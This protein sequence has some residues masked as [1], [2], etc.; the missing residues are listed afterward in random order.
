MARVLFLRSNP[1]APD[2]RVEKEARALARGGAEVHILGWDRSGGLPPLERWPQGI[3]VH[4]LRLKALFGQGLRNLPHLLRFEVALTLWLFRHFKDYDAL[5]ACDL[6]TVLPALLAKRFLGKRVVYDIFDFY[7]DMLRNVPGWARSLARRLELW[8]IGQADAVIL[9]DERRKEQIQG[10]RP[11]RLFVVYNTP[12]DVPQIPPPPLPLRIAYVGLLQKERGLFEML[13]VMARHPHWSL[14]LAGFGGDEA[15]IQKA[16][17]RL[18][19]VRF[20]GR[21]DYRKAL[22]LMASAHVLFATYDPA[23]PNHRFSSPNKVFEAMAL[24]RPIIVS[25]GMGIDTLVREKDLGWVVPYGDL[26]ALEGALIEASTW[27]QEAYRNFQQRVHALYR[28]RFSWEVMAHRLLEAH[29]IEK[30]G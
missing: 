19:N 25:S 24:G 14:D 16:A 20:H 5:H 27:T 29:G 28:S 26:E 12:E 11:K 17:S 7:A 30:G 22:E 4:R 1:V 8:A 3:T 21:V 10:A 6:D 15:G 18:S 23:I 2:P 9:A 13:Q